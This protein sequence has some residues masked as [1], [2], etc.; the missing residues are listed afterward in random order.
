MKWKSAIYICCIIITA[1]TYFL[2]INKLEA[3]AHLMVS[4]MLL[5]AMVSAY[6]QIKKIPEMKTGEYHRN[7][8]Q[9]E[10]KEI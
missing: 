10:R 2:M 1:I 3:A 7:D 5:L 4:M 8:T 9:N 6:Q